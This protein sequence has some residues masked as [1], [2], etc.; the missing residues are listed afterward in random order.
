M[1]QEDQLVRLS[2]HNTLNLLRK[3]EISPLD[4]V[5]AHIKQVEKTNNLNIYITKTLEQAIEK[6]KESEKR[7]LEGKEKPLD[8]IAVAVKDLFC[9]DKIRTTAASK[10]LENFVPTYESTVTSKLFNSGAISLGKTN[11]DE[12]AMGS[13]NTTSY[14]G[15]VINPWKRKY[16]NS[17]KLE[18]NIELTPGGSSGGSAAA[19]AAFTAM[20][21]LG[22]D[23]GGS[24]RQP[25]SFTGLVGSKPTYG[26]CSRWGMI[27]FASSLDQAGVFSRNV[28]DNALVLNEIIGFDNK[29]STSS[30]APLSDIIKACDDKNIKGMKVGI[31]DISEYEE[32]IEKDIV[33]TYYSLIEKLKKQGAEITEI[34]LPYTKYALSAYYIIAPAEC[35]SN[36]ARYDGVRY[37][38]RTEKFS[39]LEEMY[40]KSRTEGFGDEV[41]RR[42]LIGTYVLSSSKMNAYYLQAQKVR[43]IISDDFKKAFEKIDNIILPTCPTTAFGINE[44]QNDPMTMYLND[45]FTIPA[46]LSGLPC[47]SVPTQISD[48]NGLPIGMQIVSNKFN[49]H[50]MFKL[51][52]KI[53]EVSDNDFTPNNI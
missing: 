33:T 17:S 2:I 30:K 11:M 10:M 28:K 34:K 40:T 12:F 5:N 27:A 47:M 52:S 25:A 38:Y 21:S 3:K 49:E 51:A 43:R 32:Y 16:H 6:A 37:G 1:K 20:A 44:N 35:S 22:S 31:I 19:V 46:S 39:N 18:Q 42:I 9:T 4:I 50:K 26:R 23:T 48:N 53:E 36:L 29:D 41:K 14:F 8:G 45:I 15:N 13:S 24:I 7:Y